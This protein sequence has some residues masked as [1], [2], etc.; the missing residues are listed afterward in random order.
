MKRAR[1]AIRVSQDNEGITVHLEREIVAGFRNFT[2][3]SGKKPAGPPHA[4]A[5]DLVHVRIGIKLPQHAVPGGLPGDQI[6]DTWLQQNIGWWV[7]SSKS[8]SQLLGIKA[9]SDF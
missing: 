9:I 4:L 6:P 8:N 2:G 5:I 7:H 1:L 3:V